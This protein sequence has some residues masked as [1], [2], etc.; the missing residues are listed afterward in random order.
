METRF[1]TRAPPE[2]DR[3]GRWLGLRPLPTADQDELKGCPECREPIRG[4][5]RYRRATL[6][7]GLDLID[8]M[9]T[10]A[11]VVRLEKGTERLKE[12]EGRL[13]GWRLEPATERGKATLRPSTAPMRRAL[14]DAEAGARSYAQLAKLLQRG[15]K[16]QVYE[17]AVAS[18]RERVAAEEARASMENAAPSDASAA[19]AGSSGSRPRASVAPVPAAVHVSGGLRGPPRELE[20]ADPEEEEAHGTGHRAAPPDAASA[21]AGSSGGRP[22][23]SS[24]ES[25]FAVHVIGSFPEGLDWA[26]PDTGG[27]D[28]EEMAFSSFDE[29]GAVSDWDHEDGEDEEGWPVL[30]KAGPSALSRLEAAEAALAALPPA[31]ARAVWEAQCAYLDAAA[32]VNRIASTG[33]QAQLATDLPAALRSQATRFRNELSSG[34]DRWTEL[35]LFQ[36]GSMTLTP[37]GREPHVTDRRV[38]QL[39]ASEPYLKRYGDRYEMRRRQEDLLQQ[40]S[41]LLEVDDAEPVTRPVPR[42]GVGQALGRMAL[43]LS[44]VAFLQANKQSMVNGP[45][46]DGIP[47]YNAIRR[48]QEAL[49]EE[50]QALATEAEAAASD[51][52]LSLGRLRHMA[53]QAAQWREQLRRSGELRGIVEA[54]A[55]GDFLTGRYGGSNITQVLAGHLYR[56][57]NGHVYMVG[58]CGSPEADAKC[59]ECGAPIGQGS[60]N[61]LVQ[62]TDAVLG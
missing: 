5:Y 3:P 23:A 25:V 30:I 55:R 48:R 8:R 34:A 46:A 24:A 18:A 1:Y 16:R 12:V 41:R 15:P 40:G 21:A 29:W 42:G 43:Q 2:G 49:L 9:F 59:P 7:S 10:N 31:D 11:C 35:A 33:L 4:V 58:E 14:Q 17:E 27:D 28:D 56:C 60:R 53:E 22:R 62:L 51:G 20:R 13:G 50:V 36:A 32:L 45:Y 39:Q 26:D 6:K 37:G 47:D 54:M 19:A 38:A 52:E 57:A 44:R 61:A